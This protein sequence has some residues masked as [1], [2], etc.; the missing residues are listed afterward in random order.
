[1]FSKFLGISLNPWDPYNASVYP[2]LIVGNAVAN[3]VMLMLL[4]DERAA[5]DLIEPWGQRTADDGTESV[6]VGVRIG[7]VGLHVMTTASDAV[8]ANDPVGYRAHCVSAFVPA[9]PLHRLGNYPLDE[10]RFGLAHLQRVALG[11]HHYVVDERVTGNRRADRPIAVLDRRAVGAVHL[12]AD[13]HYASVQHGATELP[14]Q[15]QLYDELGQRGAYAQIHALERRT[16]QALLQIDVHHVQ[17][18]VTVYGR[19]VGQALRQGRL[20]EQ[21]IENDVYNT[22]VRNTLLFT[23]FGILE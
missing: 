22:L 16:L 8:T 12:A 4:L 20:K 2:L 19:Q 7:A 11:A 6:H 17:P 9:I 3:D 5:G 13:S 23:V 18:V 21:T 15:H 1:M 10:I 14:E